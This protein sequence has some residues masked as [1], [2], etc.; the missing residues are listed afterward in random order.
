MGTSPRA[1]APA[2]SNEKEKAPPDPAPVL[3]GPEGHA[4]VDFLARAIAAHEKIGVPF[5]PVF[6]EYFSWHYVFKGPDYFMMARYDPAFPDAWLVYWADCHPKPAGLEALRRFLD[7]AP[8]DRPG[9]MWARRL[10][11]RE[12][13]KYYSTAR[14]RRLIEAFVPPP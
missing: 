9:I 8:F 5:A 10:R 4:Y 6:D 14:L 11:G 2:S 3:T 7:L 12:E 13:L 1:A